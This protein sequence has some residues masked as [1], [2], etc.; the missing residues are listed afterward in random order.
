[1]RGWAIITFIQP[2]QVISDEAEGRYPSTS[3]TKYFVEKFQTQQSLITRNFWSRKFLVKKCLV[4][5]K[6]LER[7]YS[8]E[9][10]ASAGPI[11]TFNR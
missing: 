6:I 11:I 10:I 4:E 9:I 3:H 7:S 2:R 8:K 5:K 1:M